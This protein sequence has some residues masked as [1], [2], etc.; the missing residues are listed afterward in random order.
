[1]PLDKKWYK[2]HLKKNRPVMRVYYA[3]DKLSLRPQHNKAICDLSKQEVLIFS[4]TIRHALEETVLLPKVKKSEKQDSII[5]K[6]EKKEN[7]LLTSF[8]TQK[9]IVLKGVNFESASAELLSSSNKILLE[10]TNILKENPTILIEIS[11]H[12]D[13]VGDSQSNYHLSRN[14]AKA[15]YTFLIKNGIQKKRLTYRGFGETQFIQTNS[16]EEGRAENRRVEIKI[17]RK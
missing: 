8:K 7:E 6:A 2:K 10:V 11:G 16:T 3:F 5:I 13:N 15:V 14:R 1:M 9:K 4:D 12:T 17:I